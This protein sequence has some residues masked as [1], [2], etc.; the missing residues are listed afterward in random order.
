M[1]SP[2]KQVKKYKTP[3]HP[4]KKDR[5]E[6]EKVL[7]I[8]YGLRNKKEIYKM[9]SLLRGFKRQAKRLI[10]TDTEQARKEEMLLM[11]KLAKL[12]LMSKGDGLEKVLDLNIR[13]IL[14]RRLQTMVFKQKLTKSIDQA[15]QFVVH[16]HVMIGDKK[17][18]VPSYLVSVV[19]ESTLGF[20]PNSKLYSEEHPERVRKKEIPEEKKPEEEKDGES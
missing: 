5:I 11:E 14:D 8:E 17:V 19:E 1:S 3:T 16:R 10:A 18:N 9:E 6:E 15:R 12:G 20:A 7:V 13:D 4:W 2:K